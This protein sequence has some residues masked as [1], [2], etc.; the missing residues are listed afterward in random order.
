MNH[1]WRTIILVSILIV[2]LAG[3]LVLGYLLRITDIFQDGK[4]S[5]DV[6]RSAIVS[7]NQ[8]VQVL[9]YQ[10]QT[11]GSFGDMWWTITP[12][13]KT[14][15]AIA[16]IT[17]TYSLASLM[18]RVALSGATFVP[19]PTPKGA[20]ASI[21]LTPAASGTC[22]F[23]R[24]YQNLADVAQAAQDAFNDAGMKS[25]A[26]IHAEA[27]GEDC[28]SADGKV[29]S[30]AGMSSDFYLLATV[31]SLDDT[32]EVA[33]VVT[34]AY[35]TITKL[36]L[37]LSATLGYLDIRI[38]AGSKTGRFRAMFSQ[39]KAALKAEKGDA[40]LLAVGGM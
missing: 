22:V 24:A 4:P 6:T 28:E 8:T 39:I 13:P 19:T 12:E 17:A 36:D 32:K 37:P 15:T 3:F 27:L 40:S 9:I 38:S 16:G 1:K 31:S 34:T 14:M 25:I 11:A 20:V 29:V 23:R 5:L 35:K 33:K 2:L 21:M 10:T 7:L 30:Y 18:T 26:V